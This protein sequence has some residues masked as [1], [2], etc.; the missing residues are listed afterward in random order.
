[1]SRK[2]T[3]ELKKQIVER[4]LRGESV[5]K[6]AKEIGVRR[7]LIDKWRRIYLAEQKALIEAEE[8]ESE[9]QRLRDIEREH[10]EL[11]RKTAIMEK[12]HK[13]MLNG[14]AMFIEYLLTSCQKNVPDES[15][16]EPEIPS[17]NL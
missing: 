17:S 3:P 15:D 5:G 2:F 7:T 6:L 10:R 14:L 13:A 8:S 1:M 9:L 12:E 11:K 16:S 4:A